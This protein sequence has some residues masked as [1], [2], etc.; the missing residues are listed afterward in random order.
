MAN[1]ANFIMLSFVFASDNCQD[2]LS[3]PPRL[4]S[5]PL[6]TD[7]VSRC[8]CRQKLYVVCRMYIRSTQPCIP[9]GSLNQVP[10]SAEV[11][12][13]MSPLPGGR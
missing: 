6:D 11:R 9:P 8:C 7:H 12:A 1:L 10:A 13:G 5:S 3:P 2:F 4:P